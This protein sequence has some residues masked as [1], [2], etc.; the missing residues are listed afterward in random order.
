MQPHRARQQDLQ[1]LIIQLRKVCQHPFVFPEVEQDID[2]SI[3]HGGTSSEAIWRSAGKFELL[4]RIL[5][6]LFATGHKVSRG[7]R[8][9]VVGHR[10]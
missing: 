4:D 5:P 2:S 6:K 1:N 3:R 10:S 9:D 7:Q 8:A